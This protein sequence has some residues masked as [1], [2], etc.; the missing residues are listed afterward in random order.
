[1]DP[2]PFSVGVGISPLVVRLAGVELTPEGKEW[3]QKNLA[4]AQ[5][6]WLKLISREE[7]IL[8]CLVC[9]SRVR[10][11]WT[12]FF[13]ILSHSVFFYWH[14]QDFSS[15]FNCDEW[16]CRLAR[17]RCLLRWGLIDSDHLPKHPRAEW[18]HPSWHCMAHHDIC[19]SAG[20]APPYCRDLPTTWQSKL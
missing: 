13:A 6:V 20:C 10:P 15:W 12:D 1:M 8:H 16:H 11:K 18:A 7:D 14:M 19:Y 3:L 2:S 9:Q 4:P 5:T 17:G